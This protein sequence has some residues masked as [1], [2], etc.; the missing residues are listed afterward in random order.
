MSRDA[1]G[2]K[3]NEQFFDKTQREP[4]HAR[5]K[6]KLAEQSRVEENIIKNL[7]G[8]MSGKSKK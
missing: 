8:T 3:K 2:K 6:Y 4:H 5:T 1:E 7:Q